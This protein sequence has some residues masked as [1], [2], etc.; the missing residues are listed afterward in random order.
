MVVPAEMLA[1]PKTTKAVAKPGI[2][3]IEWEAGSHC[4]STNWYKLVASSY[5]VAS[6]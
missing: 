5:L 1:T 6:K 3:T 2:S 4:T